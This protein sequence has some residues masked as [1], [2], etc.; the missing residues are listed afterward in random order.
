MC[1]DSYLTLSDNKLEEIPEF[2]ASLC[3]FKFLTLEFEFACSSP[4]E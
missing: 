1:F 2:F 4:F 3:N